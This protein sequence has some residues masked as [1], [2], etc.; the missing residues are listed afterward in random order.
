MSATYAQSTDK[1][2]VR[3]VA[4]LAR[5]NLTEEE[6]VLFQSQ[7][8]QILAH[9]KE[10]TALDVEGVEPTAHAWP[11]QNV[12]RADEPRACVD[13]EKVLKNAPLERNGQFVVPKIIE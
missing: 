13:R 9:V 4:H 8:D 2:D 11:V 6:V 5:L 3:Y 10:L 1:I 12:F 7:L